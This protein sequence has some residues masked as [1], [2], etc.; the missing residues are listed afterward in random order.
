M[1]KYETI[2]TFLG[3][4]NEPYITKVNVLITGICGF[5]GSCFARELLSVLPGIKIWGLD[6]FL[7]E[8][9]RANLSLLRTLGVI[10]VEGDVRRPADLAKIPKV[11]WVIDCAAEPSVLAGTSGK[12]SSIDLLDHNLIGTIQMLEFCRQ[13]SAGFI[14]ISTSRVYSVPPLASLPVES[15]KEAFRPK[16]FQP[17]IGLTEKGISEIFPTTPPA[18]L[19]GTSKR[20]SELLALEYEEAFGFPVWI[21]RCSALAGSGQFGRADQGIF[22]FWIRS[23]KDKRPLKYIGFDGRGSQVRDC[24]HPKDLVPLLQK[25]LQGHKPSDPK[26]GIDARICNFSGG[27]KNS[28]SLA[29]LSEWCRTRFGPHEVSFDPQPRPYDLPWIVLDSTRAAQLWNW[30]PESSLE[31]IF[32]EISDG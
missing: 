31:R 3:K 17:E 6:N 2:S 24:L 18:S 5:V 12:M 22:S 9:S 25:Q 21:N 14:L 8:G 32:S 29:Q 13:H 10:I 1:I 4:L 30:H 7:R 26:D 23:W 11:D 15:I 20:C 19:Y 16:S 28:C 27:T